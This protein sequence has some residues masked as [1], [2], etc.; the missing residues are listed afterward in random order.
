MA[1]PRQRILVVDDD[2]DIRMLLHLG[3]KNHFEVEVAGDGRQ[4]LA[5]VERQP[6]DLIITDRMMP[7]LDGLGLVMELR[8]RPATADL[9]VIMLTALGGSDDAT[10]GLDA[11]ADDYLGKPFELPE[12]LARVRA[13][14]RRSARRD[15]VSEA[16]RSGVR[17]V[18]T[19]LSLIGV[20]QVLHLERK[21]CDVLVASGDRRAVLC[22]VD[23]ELTNAGDGQSVG[24]AAVYRV[25]AWPDPRITIKEN[26][27][28]R[29]RVIATPLSRLLLEAVRLQDEATST[30]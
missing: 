23:G 27:P 2:P 26:P 12:L 3:L 6:P 14:L 15:P 21:T 8:R 19:G 18:P 13:L 30:H 22:L 4:A 10:S 17:N 28:D 16:S 1:E 24:E 7:N 9:P 5:A 11:G 29:R 20:L 25:L